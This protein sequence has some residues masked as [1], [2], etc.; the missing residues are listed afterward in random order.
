VE[1]TIEHD[2]PAEV[3]FLEAFDRFSSAVKELLEMPD[4]QI[5]HLRVFLSQGGGRLS[6]R[7]KLREFAAL[8]PHEVLRIEALYTE[9]FG[10]AGVEPAR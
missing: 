4:R 9:C 10:A 3:R 1:Q 8:A 5:E 7:A 2:L 6:E